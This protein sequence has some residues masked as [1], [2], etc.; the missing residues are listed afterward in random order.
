MISLHHAEKGVVWFCVIIL[1]VCSKQRLTSSRDLASKLKPFSIIIPRAFGP[2]LEALKEHKERACPLDPTTWMPAQN[3]T[4]PPFLS[5]WYTWGA[6]WL[7]PWEFSQRDYPWRAPTSKKTLH[8]FVYVLMWEGKWFL[9]I[10]ETFQEAGNT[11]I[12]ISKDQSFCQCPRKHNPIEERWKQISDSLGSPQR[13]G[14]TVLWP[15]NNPRHL[16]SLLEH[17]DTVEMGHLMESWDRPN[18]DCCIKK[19]GEITQPA[20]ALHKGLQSNISFCLKQYNLDH[21]ETQNVST[22]LHR[23]L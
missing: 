15:W 18:R 16:V 21:S 19:L 10:K 7:H 6:W 12:L 5:L 20:I 13:S 23:F 3:R 9:N 2:Y 14:V 17:V 4:V 22:R 11:N 8:W 1:W